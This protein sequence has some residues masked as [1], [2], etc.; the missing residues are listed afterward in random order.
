M[1]ENIYLVGGAV[2]DG[3]LGVGTKDLD[4]AV[5]C[6]SFERMEQIVLEKGGEIF[7]SNPEFFTIRAKVPGLGAS[8]FVLCRKDGAYRDGRRPETV[9]A[10][11]ILDD[12]SRRDF[13]VNAIAKNVETGELIDPFHGQE[14]IQNKLIRCVGDPTARFLEDELRVFRA[15]RFAITKGFKLHTDTAYA[16]RDVG[17]TFKNVS[18]ERIFEELRK[19]FD[20]DWTR[21]IL[22]LEEFNLLRVLEA[23]DV[24]LTVKL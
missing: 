12:L 19:C 8:D 1:K 17:L 4:Y 16:M 10:G 6:A 2:R 15:V 9:E 14:D 20:A 7:Q 13:S 23:K 11:S 5:E 21:A 22:L 3:I 24:N 18:R